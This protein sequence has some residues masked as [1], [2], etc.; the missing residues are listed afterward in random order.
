M[1][2]YSLRSLVSAIPS[3]AI[4]N[5]SMPTWSWRRCN[6]LWLAGNDKARNDLSS[7]RALSVHAV[8]LGSH[9]GPTDT[10][11]PVCL[12]GTRP[13]C[14][15]TKS[16]GEGGL[17]LGEGRSRNDKARERRRDRSTGL[18]LRRSPTP[19]TSRFRLR[20]RRTVGYGAANLTARRGLTILIAAHLP[21]RAA[22]QPPDTEQPCRRPWASK[23]ARTWT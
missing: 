5:V 11:P 16:L 19:R 2:V 20:G 22:E 9:H 7:F 3:P 12:S 6:T 8:P 23:E 18:C 13:R 21:G 1:H 10:E 15:Q 17:A 4:A 14:D